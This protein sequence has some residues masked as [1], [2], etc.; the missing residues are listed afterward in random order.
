MKPIARKILIDQ[1][2]AIVESFDSNEIDST[3]D[4][5]YEIQKQK[6]DGLKKTILAHELAKK[7]VSMFKE[8]KQGVSMDQEIKL[9]INSNIYY[10]EYSKIINV[11]NQWEDRDTI[12]FNSSQ[13]L[14]TNEQYNQNFKD[15]LKVKRQ[16]LIDYRKT[17][18][19][20]SKEMNTDEN[21]LEKIISQEAEE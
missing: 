9:T 5:I 13:F 6:N 4:E 15:L 11:H 3:L 1:I 8:L 10:D 2:K 16:L 12:N 17:L 18:K 7:A 14:T 19:K 20:L 21:F